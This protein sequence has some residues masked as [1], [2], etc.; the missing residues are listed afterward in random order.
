MSDRDA[1]AEDPR[2][3][4]ARSRAQQGARVQHWGGALT[5]PTHC[6][7]T[8]TEIFSSHGP[9]SPGRNLALRRCSPAASSSRDCQTPGDQQQQQQHSK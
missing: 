2:W 4:E 7:Y 5:K 1:T 3:P 9:A 6:M 8:L